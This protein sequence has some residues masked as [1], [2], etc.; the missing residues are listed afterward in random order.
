LRKAKPPIGRWV[1]G[2]TVD[3]TIGEPHERVLAGVATV[4]LLRRS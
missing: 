2:S 1:D 4:P 3:S